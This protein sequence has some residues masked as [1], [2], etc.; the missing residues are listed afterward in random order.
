M[1]KYENFIKE[2]FQ[3]RPPKKPE[4]KDLA[5]GKMVKTMG[6]W[7]NLDINSQLG[8]IVEMKDYGYILIEFINTFSPRLHAGHKNRGKDKHC[9]YVS[10]DNIY[11]IIDDELATR[12]KNRQVIPYKASTDLLRIFRRMKFEPTED[13][14]DSSFFDVD[15]DN[16]DM[17]TYLPANKFEGD[18]DTKKG[19]QG[20]KVG[21][22]LKKL[23]PKLTDVQLQSI[24]DEYRA[25]FKIIVLGEGKNLDVVTGED[26]RYWYSNQHYATPA[27]GELWSSCMSSPSCGRYFSLYVDNPDKVALA[28]Y[29]NE[30]DKLLARAIVWRLDDGRVYMDRIYATS[31]ANKK[32]LRDFSK[33]N[34]MIQRDSGNPGRM[35]VTMPKDYGGKDRPK[36]GNPY[37]DTMRNFNVRRDGSYYMSNQGPLPGERHGYA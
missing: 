2:G 14:L 3:K 36:E 18:P 29:T 8:T 13:Y 25:A 27:T 33:Q 35:E 37:L 19:R 16:M 12:I 10:L 5:V 24:G 11:E 21:R 17:L 1:I 23:D 6:N 26:I 28:I 9:F 34:G 32:V 22:V 4:R 15:K 31:E 7:D 30:D 20:M